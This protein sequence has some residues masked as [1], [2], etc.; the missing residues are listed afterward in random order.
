MNASQ[1]TTIKEAKKLLIDCSCF[2]GP[3]GPV[4]ATGAT[5]ATGAQGPTGPPGSITDFTIPGASTNAL[6]YYTGTGFGAMSS[7]FYYSS[8]NVLEAHLDIIPSTDNAYSLG[9]SNIRWKDLYVGPSS[10]YLGNQAKL[11]ED[12]LGN[13]RTDIGYSAPT[14]NLST[15]STTKIVVGTTTLTDDINLDGTQLS[16]L[17]INNSL[18]PFS[19]LIYDLGNPLKRWRS[20]YIGPGTIDIAT[21]SSN[22]GTI[23]TDNDGVVY[24]QF[25]FATP[26]I[27][28]GPEI[29]TNNAVGGW[30]LQSLGEPTQPTFD[31]VI[32]QNTV[33]GLVGPVYSLIRNPVYVSTTQLTSSLVGLGTFGYIS[34]ASLQSTVVGLGSVGYI[35][36]SQLL[37]TVASGSLALQSTTRGLGNIYISSFDSLV[38]ST[39][40]GLGTFGYISSQQLT[41]TVSGL[42]NIYISSATNDLT[43]T[44]VGLGTF[45]YIS[46]SQLLSTVAS[47]SLALQSTTRGLGNIYISTATLYSTLNTFVSSTSYGN[48]LRV[49]SVFGDDNI[50]PTNKFGYPFKTINGAISNVSATQTI[51]ILPGT[52]N[53]TI[54]M[55][56]GIAIRGENI[57]TVML[58]SA[59][60]ISNTTLVT[61]GVNTRLE[62]VTMTL[63]SSNAV[64]LIGINFPSG[65]SQTSKVRTT[66]LNVSSTGAN[67]NSTIGIYSGGTSALTYTTSHAIRA[68]TVNVASQGTGLTRALYLTNSNRF[69]ARDTN[70]S[71]LGTS[72][73]GVET[74][75]ISTV[76]E[77]KECSVNGGVYD[78]NRSAGTLQLS[79]TD[80]INATANG[81][82][83]SVNTEP[84]PIFFGV[85]G[86]IG[87]GTHCLMPGT[88]LYNNLP[89]SFGLPFPQRLVVFQGLFTSRVALTGSQTAVYHLHKNTTAGT[90]FMTATLNSANQTVRVQDKSESFDALTDRLFVELTTSGGINNHTDLFC[91]LAL[92]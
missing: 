35:S 31:L 5:G 20:M 55:P 24:S 72:S 13:L 77:L 60:S 69:T 15:I 26:Y 37:S 65:T 17:T 43:S 75:N 64:D 41:S 9:S 4:G 28:I 42:G 79:S 3:E 67:T 70:F 44:I 59:N 2:R 40:I 29:S 32:Q 58:Q 8:I 91:A 62:D 18:I 21:N 78:I 82:S 39:V 80:L 76:V 19:T 16:S 84:S 22:V 92:Y 45:G 89:A 7:L 53:E 30:R 81:N 46:S 61:M 68:T 6:M 50:A 74:T 85:T 71:A 27:N 90:P 52:Y 63:Y 12:V 34:T 54:V 23:G 11:Y 57:Q 86:T 49:D 83:F 73:I 88:V 51:H 1:L 38:P 47:G 87:T 14:A 66:V 25:G 56:T 36:S 10:I 33:S 48:V